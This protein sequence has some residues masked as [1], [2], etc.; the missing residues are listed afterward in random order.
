MIG[1]VKLRRY[2][3]GYVGRF[4]VNRSLILENFMDTYLKSPPTPTTTIYLFVI[5]LLLVMKITCQCL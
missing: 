4:L 5:R 3:L 1:D 2:Q